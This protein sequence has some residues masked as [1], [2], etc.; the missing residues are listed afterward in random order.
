MAYNYLRQTFNLHLPAA[1]TLRCWY[2]TIET[3]PDFTNASFDALKQRAVIK[4]ENGENLL[5]GLL[6]DGMFIRQHSQWDKAGKKFLG[7]NMVREQAEGRVSLPLASNA[8]VLMV[9][10]LEGDFKIPIGYFLNNGTNHNELADIIDKVMFKL[11]T[12]GCTLTSITFDGAAENIAV[13]KSLGATIEKTYI[14]NQYDECNKVYLVLDPPHMLKLIRNCLANKE[15]LFDKNDGQIKWEM[16]RNLVDLQIKEN[17]NFGNKLTKTHV[18]FQDRKMN[19]R[20]AAQTVSKSTSNS[21]KFLDVH[22]KNPNF[23]NSNSTSEYFMVFNNLFDIMNSKRNHCNDDYKR[24]FSENTINHFNEFFEY[25]KSY[26]IGLQLIENGKKV[27]ILNSRSFTPFFGFL[28]NIESFKGIYND[29]GLNE[30]YTFSICQD[31]LES[32]FGC[33]RRMNG[34]NDN[35]SEQQFSAAYKKLLFQNEITSSEHSNCQNDITKI[36]F[37]SSAKH[38]KADRD[39]SQA[40]ETLKD[41]DFLNPGVSAQNFAAI[42]NHSMAY[43]ASVVEMSVFIEKTI[44][45]DEF[46]EFQSANSGMYQPCQSTVDIISDIERYLEKYAGL[47]VSFEASM[48]HV[49]KNIDISSYYTLSEFADGHNHSHKVDLIRL[50]AETF[51]DKSSTDGC[52]ILTRESKMSLV[53]NKKF[54]D[55]HRMGQ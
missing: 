41:F 3:S 14:I 4:K 25:A 2:S 7:H 18:E 40:M 39:V 31:H 23:A 27:S 30:L 49:L 42:K 19:V 44:T 12:I 21:I 46:I 55:T 5:V 29:Y 32:F 45:H 35:P 53:R 48:E 11:S 51:L 28:Q 10:G 43:M 13:G 1:R 50:I 22:M 17:T 33:I 20:I 37:V 36:L 38:V 16:V 9:C 52:K 8:L 24:P 26:I 15:I 6:L 54:K 47:E 34:C